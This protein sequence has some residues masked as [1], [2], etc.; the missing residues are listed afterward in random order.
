MVKF[1]ADKVCKI[2]TDETINE[3]FRGKRVRLHR[4]GYGTE[5][6]IKLEEPVTVAMTWRQPVQYKIYPIGEEFNLNLEN[7]MEY[8]ISTAN[9]L[10]FFPRRLR[11]TSWETSRRE[12]MPYEYVHLER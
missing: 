3:Y 11:P 1:K 12:E 10:G 4:M 9:V 7:L 5:V 6:T 2:K 8:V